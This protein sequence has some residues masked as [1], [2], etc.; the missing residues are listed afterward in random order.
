MHSYFLK[1]FA[2]WQKVSSGLLLFT[3]EW[4]VM[5]FSRLWLLHKTEACVQIM[6]QHMFWRS[7]FTVVHHKGNISN[8]HY[9]GLA[10][11]NFKS[12]VMSVVVFHS[13]MPTDDTAWTER[14]PLSPL[15]V[16][17]NSVTEFNNKLLVLK[18]FIHEY[19]EALEHYS[20]KYKVP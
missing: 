13:F 18:I 1:N 2:L 19:R 11:I 3:R 15:S 6:M 8:V 20:R 7:V 12:L 9:W 10:V 5:K 16:A 14:L 4:S 17:V